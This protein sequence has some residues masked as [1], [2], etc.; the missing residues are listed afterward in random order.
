MS[1]WRE[2]LE[3]FITQRQ[4]D[5]L[6]RTRQLRY[7]PQQ[8]EQIVDG[9]AM[10]SFC[11]NDY[12]G[13]AHHPHIHAALVHGS[14]TQGTGAGASHLINGHSLAHHQL[15]QALARFCHRPRALVFSTGYMANI[16]VIS[17]LADRHCELFL[18]KANHAS[19]LD[20]A[21]LSG[22]RWRRYPHQDWQ[23]LA[24]MLKHSQA[25]HKLIITDG[26]FSMDGDLAPLD[27]LARIAAQY[28][29]W[30]MVDDAHG[31]GVIGA[32]GRGCQ[33]VYALSAQQIPVLIGTL[34]KAFGTFG[35]WVAGDELLIEYLLQ[36]ARSAIYTTALP[37][38]MAQ[39]AHAAL[40]IAQAEPWRRARVLQWV[41]YFRQQGADLPL[42]PSTTPIQGIV[43]GDAQ[44]ALAASQRLRELGLLVT[45]IRPPTVPAGS[46]R[47]RITFSASHTQAQIDRLLAALHD[48]CA[49]PFG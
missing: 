19:L 26:V 46:A 44:T 22:A 33:E 28:Q 7:G 11:S 43:F 2:K 48:V 38:A 6:Y 3:N 14:E 40:H 31:L 39:A 4:R 37:P 47:L 30:L 41:S 13:L 18:D 42:L 29:A 24:Q 20:G 9:Q 5:N 16:G 21:Q 25:Q 32:H 36:R 17:A 8:P 45:A 27:H 23:A 49:N 12:L 1:A 34:G 10:V 15:E 35:A